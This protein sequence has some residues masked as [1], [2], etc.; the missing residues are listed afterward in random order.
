MPRNPTELDLGRRRWLLG[1]GVR[2]IPYSTCFT[3][4]DD[5]NGIRRHRNRGTYDAEPLTIGSQ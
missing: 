4:N 3:R 1:S 5:S 2:A